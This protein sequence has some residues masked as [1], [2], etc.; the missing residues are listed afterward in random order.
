MRHRLRLRRRRC[1]HNQ[2]TRPISSTNPP[3]TIIAKRKKVLCS[4]E[5]KAS[6]IPMAVDYSNNM[7]V[8]RPYTFSEHDEMN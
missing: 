5:E 8:K 4:T 3:P 1:R 2:P 7:H 6:P